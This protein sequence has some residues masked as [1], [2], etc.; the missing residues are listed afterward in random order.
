MNS[1]STAYKVIAALAPYGVKAY[2]PNK[3]KS[4]SP[5]RVGSDSGAFNVEIE[6]DEHG[7][8]KDFVTGESGSLYDLAEHLGLALPELV[9]STLQ[10]YAERQG[11]P[12]QVFHAAGWRE[13]IKWTKVGE[14]PALSFPT[15]TG[16]RWRI[17]GEYVKQKPKFVSDKGYRACWY[18]LDRAIRR[19]AL[20]NQPLV[21]CNGEPSVL[22]ADHYGV[23]AA[24][25]TGGEGKSVTPEQV[26]ELRTK[27]Q[28][29]VWVALDCDKAGR[30]GSQIYYDAL[31]PHYAHLRILDFAHE[32]KGYD[33]ANF[34]NQHG[35][36][37]YNALAALND[38]QELVQPTQSAIHPELLLTPEQVAHEREALAKIRH[39]AW[40]KG[41]HAGMKASGR[42]YWMGLG[43][44][45]TYINAL[46]LGYSEDADALTIPYFDAQGNLTNIEYRPS[47]DPESPTYQSTLPSLLKVKQGV[48]D[49]PVILLPDTLQAIEAAQYRTL[50]DYPLY[51]LPHMPIGV[52]TI[53]RLQGRTVVIM[54]TTEADPRYHALRGKTKVLQLPMSFPDMV[55]RG[56]TA[57]QVKQYIRQA[58]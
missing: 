43:A 19:A 20:N 32:K 13:C 42:E 15:S 48:Q 47:V 53:E 12:A 36:N 6:G 22:V 55:K 21:I 34:C 28:G 4:N 27:W 10:Q 52:E 31:S 25:L 16:T 29:A 17:L 9:I 41:F 1:T 56:M 18:G 57:S 26:D 44:T 49:A 46:Q 11:V 50:A 23:A 58:S 14:F 33:L 51:A 35:T 54:D 39:E 30:T 5:L 2:A 24:C 3:Y 37:T 45:E 7:F 38:L 8:Y 40:W